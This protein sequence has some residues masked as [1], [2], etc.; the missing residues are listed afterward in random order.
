MT[1][2]SGLD[3][4][5]RASH[6]DTSEYHVDMLS[7]AI[8]ATEIMAKVSK[9]AGDQTQSQ[10]YQEKAEYLLGKL[11]ELH[12]S[13]D[14]GVIFLTRILKCTAVLIVDKK[15]DDYHFL[16]NEL[17]YGDT[18]NRDTVMSACTPKMD[19]LSTRLFLD[20]PTLPEKVRTYLQT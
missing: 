6:P 7:W 19:H 13:D 10:L 11:D 8:R 17:P 2:A 4:Y 20:V 1:L 3:D 12:W 18:A 15:P 9:F 16:A 14:I 5:P